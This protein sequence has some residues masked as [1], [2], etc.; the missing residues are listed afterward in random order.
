MTS[1]DPPSWC[2][3]Q[4]GRSAVLIVAPHG[5]RRAVQPPGS[6]DTPRRKINDLHTAD[7]ANE[8]AAALD[9]SAVINASVDR[10]R[11]DLNRISQ[12]YEHAAWF[13]ALLARLLTDILARHPRAE[14]LFIHGW[15]VVQ[16]R[17]DVGI[18]HALGT[19]ADAARAAPFLTVSADYAA[20]R[21]RDLQHA[22]SAAGI[23]VTFGARYPAGHPNNLLQLFRSTGAGGP[24]PIPFAG[25]LERIEAVQLELGIT[26]RWPGPRRRAFVD[27]LARTF[28]SAT[29]RPGDAVSAH[30]DID[31]DGRASGSLQLYDARA[32]VALAVRLDA[33]GP[34]GGTGRVLL[35]LAS[36]RLALFVG[37]NPCSGSGAEGPWFV[38]RPHGCAVR[39]DGWALATDGGERFI[40]LEDAFAASTL[41]PLRFSLDYRKGTSDA[42]GAASGYVEIAGTRYALDAVAHA[43]RGPLQRAHRQ[44]ASYLDLIAGF[45]PHRALR[46]EHEIPG[47]SLM[48]ELS[49][50]GE[51]RAALSSVAIH[52]E[53]DGYAPAHIAIDGG[54]IACRPLSRM[55]IIRPLAPRRVARITV[56]AAEFTAGTARGYGF[57][58][59]GRVLG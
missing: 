58:E 15:N 46:I 52:L 56:G 44:C 27:A 30:A 6:P 24:R 36:N 34:H 55:A 13:P 35:F 16:A 21:L 22:C 1:A 2:R 42:Y 23:G 48:H 20:S 8:L 32:R 45:G 40:D 3:W 10:N 41:V 5:G 9:A 54:R 39:F 14:V 37:E 53:R 49:A 28:A 59:Y 33:G 51:R 38:R 57:Y 11:L 4:R 47:R 26:L 12:V 29:T 17:C 31:R 19:P 18:G 25:G 50:A 7:V 43:D